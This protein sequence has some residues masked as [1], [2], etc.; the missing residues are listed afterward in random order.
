MNF[1]NLGCQLVGELL[2]PSS[3]KYDEARKVWNG[4][5][6]RRPGAIARCQTSS[7]VAAAIRYAAEHGVEVA[8]RS[9]G[10]S[11]PGHS[12]CDDGLVID[13]G[14]INAV[15]VDADAGTAR[16]GGGALLRDLD[17]A[18][19][20]FGMAT[21]AGA[22]S[23]TGVGGLTLGG[24]FGHLMRKYGLT[25]DSLLEVEMV[26]ADGSLV[27]ANHDILPNLFW[28]V[29]GGGGNFGI[30]TEFVFRAHKISEP[31]IGIVIHE[32]AAAPEALRKW[33]RT[34]SASPPDELNWCSF[35]R[36]ADSIPGTPDHLKGR[37]VLLSL[38]EWH[39]DYSEGAPVIDKIVEDLGGAAGFTTVVP[40]LKL[41]TFIDEISE[42]GN[43]VWTKAG[44]FGKIDEGLI[45]A[46]IAS[47]SE[48]ESWMSTLEVLPLGGKIDAV[49]SE[50]TAFPH[51]AARYVFNVIGIWSDPQEN[52]KHVEWVRSAY[53]RLTP[54]MTGGAYIN[55]M[56]GDETGGADAGFG[57]SGYHI[58]RLRE[59]KLRYDPEN[60]FRGNFNL[61][62]G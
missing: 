42:H 7:D 44:F 12:V 37:P 17:E 34:M 39:G 28:A 50:A 4:M 56:G 22:V 59:V 19:Q 48:I 60:I 15:T 58:D 32:L 47:A 38:L 61:K 40:F 25:I 46:L 29:R 36:F 54:F 3:P 6:D 52:G 5:I 27:R 24:G 62:P 2:L 41:Q 33:H 26:L 13:L 21:P 53:S 20:E 43:Q 57:T 18:T 1:S 51:R 35:F 55:Y 11:I 10:H 23:H 49:P 30:V 16:V 9:G 45:E 14:G 31:Y 8:V